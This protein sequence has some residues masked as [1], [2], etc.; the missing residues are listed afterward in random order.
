V[1]RVLADDG[2]IVVKGTWDNAN[3]SKIEKIAEKNGFLLVEKNIIENDGYKQSDG[4]PIT[5]DKIREYTFK[6]K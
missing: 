5:K 2:V 1:L 3:I 6:R 4:S